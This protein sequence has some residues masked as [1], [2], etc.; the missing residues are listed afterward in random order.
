MGVTRTNRVKSSYFNKFYVR[1]TVN[2]TKTW[3]TGWCK[4]YEMFSA[5]YI[6]RWLVNNN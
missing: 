3:L 6:L 2:D 1:N 4:L 5:F